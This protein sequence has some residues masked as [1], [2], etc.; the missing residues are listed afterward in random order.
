MTFAVLAEF[1]AYLRTMSASSATVITYRQRIQALLTTLSWPAEGYPA[2]VDPA[3][4][5]MHLSRLSPA[6]ATQTRCAWNCFAHW[7]QSNWHDVPVLDRAEKRSLLSATTF[8]PAQLAAVRK[9]ISN[10]AL[11]E[12]ALD[13]ADKLPVRSRR[14]HVI[15]CAAQHGVTG[16]ALDDLAEKLG[17][18]KEET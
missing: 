11:G 3:V 9:M 8:S 4:V 15:Q 7:C 14:M 6:A 5:I 12:Q 16:A 18:A 10:W 2:H 13:E 1:E 17:F